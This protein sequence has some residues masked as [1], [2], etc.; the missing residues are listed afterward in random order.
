MYKYS[1]LV[2]ALMV[3][4][5]LYTNSL[6]GVSAQAKAY[7]KELKHQ[8]RAEGYATNIFVISGRRW[9]WDNWVLSQ[10]SGAASKSKHLD[11]VAIDIIVLDVNK[12]GKMN[13]SDVDIVY[14]IL[15][16]KI[17]FSDKFRGRRKRKHKNARKVVLCFLFLRLRH[18]ICLRTKNH[19]PQ[20][21]HWNIQK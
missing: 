20:R 13:A 15:D 5:W 3:L 10:L 1:G 19:W 11:G 14:R 6:I 7:Y 4:I 9:Q 8:L 2:L 18:G 17:T 12:D 16:K 21:R